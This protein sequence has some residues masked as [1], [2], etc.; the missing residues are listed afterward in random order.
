MGDRK[1]VVENSVKPI[2]TRPTSEITDEEYTAFYKQI[3]KDSDEPAAKTHFSAEGEIGFKAMLFVPGK[4]ARDLCSW[5]RKLAKKISF[6]DF[7]SIYLD[8]VVILWST[9]DYERLI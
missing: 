5:V 1:Y 4:A 2:W 6:L 3:S 8:S 9:Q 7:L